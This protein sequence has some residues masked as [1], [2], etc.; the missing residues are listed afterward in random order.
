MEPSYILHTK[1]KELVGVHCNLA[2]PLHFLGIPFYRFAE[3]TLQEICIKRGLDQKKLL[4]HLQESQKQTVVPS[5]QSLSK[6]SVDVVINHLK[7]THMWFIR[8]RLPFISQMIQDIDSQ[9]FNSP[10]IA[11]DMKIIFPE[12]M[13][14]FIHHIYEEEDTLF[15]YIRKLYK[16]KQE[17]F[18]NS[19]EL[20]YLMKRNSIKV[21]AQQHQDDDDEMAGIRYLTNHY[22]LPAHAS[23]Y[24]KVIYSELKKFEEELMLH[25][26]IENEILFPKAKALEKAVVLKLTQASKLN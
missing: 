16:A 21:Y 2:A 15:E 10:E 25:S 6:S 22:Q 19:T 1:L 17:G 11:E 13:E 7:S 24:M 4:L 8:Y 20:F 12:F 9:L 26:C 5:Y 14:E 18:M 23:P 3:N